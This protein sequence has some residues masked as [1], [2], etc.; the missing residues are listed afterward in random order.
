MAL[1]GIVEDQVLFG[2]MLR[3]L[4]ERDLDHEVQFVS[5]TG[6]D[7]K[8][9]F[10]EHKV[11]LLLLDLML[12]DCEGPS[13]AGDL[14]ALHPGSRILAISGALTPYMLHQA[15][16]SR[17]DGFVDKGSPL[18][19]LRDAISTV[20]KGD[21]YFTDFVTEARRELRTNPDSFLKLLTKA[22]L[23]LMASFGQGLS[24]DEIA[25]RHRL[26]A[27]TVQT[28]RRN[29][30]AK[31]RIHTSLDLMRYAIEQGFVSFSLSP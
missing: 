31:L 27:T 15:M 5:H 25:D 21:P 4:C 10:R 14:R 23:S 2:S 28:H 24:N 9:A 18:P 6:A 19:K 30:M 17:L 12:P 29:I 3:D 7:A 22:E 20:L 26:S 8:R 13:L 1:I 11:E 16:S